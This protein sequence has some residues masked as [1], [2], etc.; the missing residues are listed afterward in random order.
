MEVLQAKTGRIVLAA[1]LN[2]QPTDRFPVVDWKPLEM[3]VAVE[4]AGMVGEPTV[5]SGSESEE[6]DN[7]FRALIVKQFRVGARL[8]PGFYTLRIGP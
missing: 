6:V 3:V 5:T 2:A 4:A 8:P 7:Y 1:P